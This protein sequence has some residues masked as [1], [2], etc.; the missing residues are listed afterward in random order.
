MNKTKYTIPFLALILLIPIV[1]INSFAQTPGDENINQGPITVNEEQDD[2]SYALY[3]LLFPDS[4]VP[5]EIKDQILENLQ[6][7]EPIPVPIPINQKEIG[8]KASK[9]IVSI[10]E[11]VNLETKA[12]KQHELDLMTIDM[13]R[14]GVVIA[15]KYE[16]DPTVWKQ[17]LEEF[18][19][20]EGE[21]PIRNVLHRIYDFN[22]GVKYFYSCHT[23]L[24][25]CNSSWLYSNALDGSLVSPPSATLPSIASPGYLEI[26]NKIKYI[27]EHPPQTKQVD[28]WVSVKTSDGAWVASCHSDPTFTWNYNYQSA[29]FFVCSPLA[30]GADRTVYSSI[31][32]GL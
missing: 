19:T 11:D 28:S 27:G 5:D 14:A 8:E 6:N 10:N 13:L 25:V 15:E 20:D 29:T 2:K 16:Q 18:E 1:M 4:N 21:Y 22:V 26:A 31:V 12:G 7:S 30:S 9:L 32:V 3:D 23:G 17:L 24:L